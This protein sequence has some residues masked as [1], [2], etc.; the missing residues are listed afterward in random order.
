MGL[1]ICKA[2]G[3]KVDILGFVLYNCLQMKREEVFYDF[4]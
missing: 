4:S 2:R 3:A 1:F